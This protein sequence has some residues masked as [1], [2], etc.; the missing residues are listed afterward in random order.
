MG[1]L[2]LRGRIKSVVLIDGKQSVLTGFGEQNR[3]DTNSN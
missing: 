1:K 3:L 2:I